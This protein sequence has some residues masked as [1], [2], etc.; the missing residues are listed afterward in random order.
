MVLRDAAVLIGAGILF[1]VAATLAAAP[2]LRT[3]LFG[4]GSRDPM[5]LGTVCIFVALTGLLAAYLPAL[6]AAAIDPMQALR[7]D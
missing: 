7:T 4:T 5:V 2:V 6:R 1:G 3:M